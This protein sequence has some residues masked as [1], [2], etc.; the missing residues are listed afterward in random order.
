MERWAEH[1]SE[2]Y[3]RQNV[4]T[5]SALDATVSLPRLD[6]LDAEPTMDELRHAIKQLKAGKAPGNDGIP[7]IC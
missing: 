6:D 2:L 7:L 3:S 4:V 5:S 1:Y